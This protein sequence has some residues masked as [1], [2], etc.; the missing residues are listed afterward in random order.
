MFIPKTFTVVAMVERNK[1]VLSIGSVRTIGHKKKIQL[2]ISLGAPTT[3]Y[4]I[5]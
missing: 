2:L 5:H 1:L 4:F 3:G